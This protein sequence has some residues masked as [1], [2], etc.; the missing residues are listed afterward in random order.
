MKKFRQ[1]ADD[2]LCSAKRALHALAEHW[3]GTSS[4][5]RQRTE[6]ELTELALC[7][8]GLASQ[9]GFDL[10]WL[11]RGRHGGSAPERAR[12]VYSRCANSVRYIRH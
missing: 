6:S 1:D 10:A 12:T 3:R 9:C 7:L 11:K 5:D 2:P 8:H 4:A